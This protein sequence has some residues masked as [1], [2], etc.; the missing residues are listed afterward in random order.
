MDVSGAERVTIHELKELSGGEVEGDGVGSGLEADKGVATVFVRLK[1]ATTMVL[2][3]LRRLSV[4]E[5]VRSLRTATNRSEL[6]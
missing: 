6:G 4:V 2:R 3:L 5:T 1:T